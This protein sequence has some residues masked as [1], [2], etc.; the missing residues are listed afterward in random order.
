MSEVVHLE[1]SGS[2]EKKIRISNRERK[3]GNDKPK[4]IAWQ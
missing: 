4:R 1:K 2:S 3:T